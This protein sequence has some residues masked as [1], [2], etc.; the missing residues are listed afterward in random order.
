MHN[1]SGE[2]NPELCLIVNF[3][4][5]IQNCP[6]SEISERLDVGKKKKP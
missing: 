3:G 4:W 5:T 2:D 6:V 1:A